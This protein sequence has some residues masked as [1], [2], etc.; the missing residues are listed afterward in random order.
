[1]SGD[2]LVLGRGKLFFQ[3]Y[4][5][6][7]KTGGVKGFLGNVPTVS[8]AQTTTQLD[9]YSSQAGLKVKDESIVL[10]SD[11]VITFD[12]DNI[13][14]GNMALWFGG[15]DVDTLPADAPADLGAIAVIGSQKPIYGALFFEAD[16]P[17]GENANYWWPFVNLRPSGNLALLGDTWQTMSFTAEALK[18]DSGTERVYVYK[19]ADGSSSAAIDTTGTFTVDSASVSGDVIATTATLTAST[20]Q[21]HLVPFEV[22]YTLNGGTAGEDLTAY[23]FINNGTVVVGSMVEVVGSTGSVDMTIP[24]VGTVHV[25]AFTNIAGTGSPIGTSATVVAT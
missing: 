18:R 2:N 12:S 16:N 24:A 3:P 9:H 21:V 13:N 25:E 15:N 6:G 14:V 8:I 1:M 20:P 5:I 11:Q 22:T 17:V 7:Q 23:L 19:T 10:Q 4:P